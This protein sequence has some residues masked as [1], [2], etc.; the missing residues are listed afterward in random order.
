MRIS[1]TEAVNSAP[2]K[3]LVRMVESFTGV[4]Q[5]ER[6][7]EQRYHYFNQGYDVWSTALELL[8]FH[9]EQQGIPLDQIPRTGPLIFVSNHP[10]GLPDGIVS[11]HLAHQVR[12]D[13]RLMA[14]NLI[15]QIPELESWVLPVDFADTLEARD[16]NLRSRAEALRILKQGGALVIFPA[17]QV[18]TA[19]R[20]LGQAVESQWSSFLGRLILATGA[21]VVPLRF[22]GQNTWMFHLASQ[23]SETVRLAMLVRETCKLI[24]KTISVTV[25]ETISNNQLSNFHDR[26]KLVNFLQDLTLNLGNPPLGSVDNIRVLTKANEDSVLNSISPELTKL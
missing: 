20:I 23:I 7:L 8:N 11:C 3:A 10:F 24:G 2:A 9:V 16:T 12:N 18:A 5:L 26:R 13:F 1:Y 6:L 17:G 4:R 19:P 25:G 15:S 21:N 14:I 22:H